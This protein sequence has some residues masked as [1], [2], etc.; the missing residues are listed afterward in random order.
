MGIRAPRTA[1]HTLAHTC[2][3]AQTHL[4]WNNGARNTHTH[5]HTHTDLELSMDP[6]KHHRERERERERET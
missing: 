5:T 4:R 1:V 2:I 3:R 6:R